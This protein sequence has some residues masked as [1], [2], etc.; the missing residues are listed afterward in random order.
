MTEQRYMAPTQEPGIGGPVDLAGIER[1]RTIRIVVLSILLAVNFAAIMAKAEGWLDWPGGL[2]LSAWN[3]FFISLLGFLGWEVLALGIPTGNKTETW[4]AFFAALLAICL[5]LIGTF[6]S[7]ALLS[8]WKP[9]PPNA[10]FSAIPMLGGFATVLPL[11]LPASI[12]ANRR[13]KRLVRAAGES[14]T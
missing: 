11:T 2:P 4:L 5:G 9:A 3:P 10:F 12:L 1:Y 14:G 6:G 8:L 13:Y 7:A